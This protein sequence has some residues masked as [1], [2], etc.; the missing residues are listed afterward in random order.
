M[1]A[2]RLI[3]LPIGMRSLSMHSRLSQNACWPVDLFTRKV[4]RWRSLHVNPSR[5]A[6]ENKR[7]RNWRVAQLAVDADIGARRD[8]SLLWLFVARII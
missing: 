5:R 1:L 4:D 6:E 3:S 7:C 8:R 2:H